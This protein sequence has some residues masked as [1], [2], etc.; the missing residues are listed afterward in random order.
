MKYPEVP[1]MHEHTGF[2]FTPVKGSRPV[3]GTV[4]PS[5]LRNAIARK[6]LERMRDR[7]LLRKH[8]EEI[9]N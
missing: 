7:K 6:K 1:A 3:A 2:E 5:R 9:W 4:K 8:I